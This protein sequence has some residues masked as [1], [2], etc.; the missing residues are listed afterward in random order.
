MKSIKGTHDILPEEA[1]K[2]QKL[3]QIAR[4][5]FTPFGYHEI[6]P[7]LMEWTELFARGIGEATDIVEKEMYSFT[8]SKDRSISL[9]PEATA[10]VIRS[11]IE[12]KLYAADEESKVYTIGPMFRHERPQ[13]GRYRQFHQIDAEAIGNPGPRVDVE[14]I[15]MLTHYLKRVGVRDVELAI[16]SLGCPECRPAYRDALTSF[17]LKRTNELCA[18]C[19][20]RISLNPL[21]VLDC[22]VPGCREVVR[23]APSIQDHLDQECARHFGAVL[24][25]LE[26][27]GVPFRVNERLVRGL[28]YYTRTSFEVLASNLGAQDAVAGGGRYDKLAE[29]LG[30]PP[31]PAIGF[32]IGMERLA[33]IS[34]LDARPPRPDLYI[35]A[36]GES[37]QDFAFSLANRLRLAGSIVELSHFSKSLKA[38]MRRANKLNAAHTLIVGDSELERG[39]A[40]LKDMG[41]SEQKE[42][43]LS[44]PVEEW[45]ADLRGDGSSPDA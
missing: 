21:R 36:L 44:R 35:A 5:V 15:V 18:D 30:G 10:G 38:H 28:D 27:F 41:S 32:A 40:N 26:E 6:R 25:G 14:L 37:A 19:V 12:N 45:T 24:R 4:D 3:E 20:R 9:R 23:D 13:K 39:A 11:Y 43:S 33:L 8:D 17:L 42:V 2:W 7:P 1:A 16:N 29:M 31:T 22:K 34:D